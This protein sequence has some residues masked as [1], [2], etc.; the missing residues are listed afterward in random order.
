MKNKNL[1]F[2]LGIGGIGMSSIAQYLILKGHKVYGFDNSH[3]SITKM[4]ENKGIILNYDNSNVF[5]YPHNMF[6]CKSSDTLKQYY[7]SIFYV[8][9]YIMKTR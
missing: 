9:Q 1:Y 4:L 7:N 8:E 5:F 6:I 3:S 2:L